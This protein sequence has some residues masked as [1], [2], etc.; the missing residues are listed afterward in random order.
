MLTLNLAIECS[1]SAEL[2]DVEA[3]PNVHEQSH[4]Y[5]ST[6]QLQINYPANL[7]SVVS[8]SDCSPGADWPANSLTF[9][10]NARGSSSSV[11]M[12]SILQPPFSSQQGT[13]IS[14][15]RITFLAANSGSGAL[16]VQILGMAQQSG[17]AVSNVSAV[18]AAGTVSSCLML[19]RMLWWN[20]INTAQMLSDCT[21]LANSLLC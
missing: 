17:A 8:E 16:S 21:A 4:D 18:A 5:A 2:S 13:N 6:L 10:C 12:N 14:V 1:L 3:L 20:G 11:L 9:V 19:L 7:L 15:A